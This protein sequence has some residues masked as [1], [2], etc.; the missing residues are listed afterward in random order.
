VP[1]IVSYN[2]H[3]ENGIRWWRIRFAPLDFLI[4]PGIWTR[5]TRIVPNPEHDVDLQRGIRVG[6]Y[7][8]K[9]CLPQ[10]YFDHGKPVAPWF[11]R[12]IRH[13]ANL[14]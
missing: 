6:P 4:D 9:H 11:I 5:D 8:V 3:E 7:R 14:S 10:L 13:F 2:L 12:R 1:R